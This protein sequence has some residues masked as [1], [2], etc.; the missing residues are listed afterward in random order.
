MATYWLSFRLKENSTYSDR[1]DA[2][3]ETIRVN[4]MRWWPETSSFFVFETVA[5]IDELAMHVKKQIDPGTD[6]VLIGMPVFKSARLIGKNDDQDI[7]DLI[8]FVKTV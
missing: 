1:Y 2:L 7:F 3:V 4:S 6:L 8:P 5:T